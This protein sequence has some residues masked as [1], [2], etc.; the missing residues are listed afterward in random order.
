MAGHSEHTISLTEKAAQVIHDAF[1][2]EKV[3]KQTSFVRVG[4][5]P[6][7]CSGWK[8]D[9]DFAE[10]SQVNESDLVFESRGIKV[11]VEDNC[12]NDILGSLE[13]DFGGKTMVE[14]GFVFKRLS[15]GATC[16]CGESFTPLK[17]LNK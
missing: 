14:Q 15:E 4:A 1:D 8:F 12:L 10:A 5:H 3:D 9:M 16:G 11:V 2:A 13:I 7:G 17:E 6:G